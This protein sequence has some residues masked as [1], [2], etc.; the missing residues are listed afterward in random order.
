MSV[1]AQAPGVDRGLSRRRFLI[2]GASAGTGLVIGIYLPGCSRRAAP[3]GPPFEPNAWLRI[4]PDGQ[5]TI[6]VG[7]SEMGQGV[8]TALP[9][10]VAEE[11]EADWTTVRIEQAVSDRERY[12]SQGTGGSSSVRTSWERLGK[13]GAA[14]REMLI[15]AAAGI[16][17]ADR[18]EC[19]AENG[20]VIHDPSGRRLG[21]GELTAAAAGVPIPENPPLKDPGKFRLLG[22]PVHRL[23]TP[24]KVDG[25][26]QYGIDFRTEGMLRAVIARSAP[27]GGKV[28]AFDPAGAMKVPGVRQVVQVASGVAVVA[29]ST[30]AAMQGREALEVR[31]DP[32]PNAALTSAAIRQKFEAMSRR[33]GA[34]ARQEGNAAAAMAGAVKR[35]EAVYE[36]PYLDH[37]PMEPMNCTARVGADEC[38]IWAPT[39]V[40]NSVQSEVARVTG[41]APEKVRVHTTLLGGGFGR[42]LEEDYAIDA[43][44][45]A[46]AAGAPVQV[47]WSREEDIRHGFY[48]PASY[49]RLAAAIG[50]DGWPSAWTHRIVAPSIVGQRW[51]EEIK[52]GLD[53][54]AVEGAANIAYNIPH[55][56]VEYVMANTAVP[57]GWWR[58]VYSTQNAFANECFLDEVAAAAG[59]DPLELRLHLLRD[60]PKGSPPLTDPLPDVARVR[61]VL[62]LA[63]GKAG[64]GTPLSAGRGRGIAAHF[65]FGSYAAEVAEVSVGPAGEL[66]VERVVCAI[67]CGRIVNPDTIEAQ[68]EGSV[69]FG[70]TAA[71]KGAI[72][73]AGGA[74]E[75]SNFHDYEMLRINEMPAVEVHIVP[76]S[77]PP[78]GIGEPGV[79]PVFA[80]L[81]N[82]VFAATGRRIRRLPIRAEDLKP[83]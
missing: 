61:G 78:G 52:K 39:Q 19:R 33:P 80:A 3:E 6:W 73:I 26:A 76:S 62:E 56:R 60:Q 34:T 12:G 75:Q 18:G 8:R 9:M 50:R 63:A 23:D 1:R 71:L 42:R 57:I 22:K 21:Y 24:G 49:H 64:W 67:D 47:V 46:K 25:S 32:G 45:V 17:N 53:E 68:M 14:A 59:K 77:A 4:A 58:A 69:A 74:V 66:K 81:A 48:R 2:T 27:F 79:P 37:A 54:Q 28:A 40:P 35:L 10:L 13:A 16:W 38:E 11:L 20:T 51:P 7:K 15:T 70:L 65:S 36:V 31:W 5:T 44:Q 29:D 72:T 55:I 43:A 30:W 83:A 82:A 41:L